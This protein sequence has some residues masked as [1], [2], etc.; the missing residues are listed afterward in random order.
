MP[1]HLPADRM[2]KPPLSRPLTPPPTVERGASPTPAAPT[3]T[4][5]FRE[6]ERKA[7]LDALARCAGNQ[8]RAAELLGIARRTFCAKLKDYDI[9]RPRL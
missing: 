3:A 9:P 6:M 7:I 8:T 5:S 1:E 4:P 2:T